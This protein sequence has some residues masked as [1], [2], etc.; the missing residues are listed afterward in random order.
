MV[1][2]IEAGQN[3]RSQ[4]CLSGIGEERKRYAR[5]GTPE[6]ENVGLT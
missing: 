3:Y 2:K 4:N 6:H 1:E 5:L